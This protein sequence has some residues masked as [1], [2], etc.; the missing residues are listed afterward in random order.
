MDL[1]LAISQGIGISLATGVRT[2][3]APLVVGA[4]ARADAV[5]D[6]EHTGFEFLESVWWLALMLAFVI[7]VW[8][9]DRSDVEI[10][11]AAWVVVSMGLGALLFAGA[12]EDEDYFGT[13]GL[14][15]GMLGA[16]LGFAAARAFFGGAAERLEARGESGGTI[17][18]LGDLAAVALAALAVVAPPVSYLA[19]AF[20]L[21]VLL[22]R[23]RREGQ[24]YEG[25]R[26]LR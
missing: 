22:A 5:I 23:R 14:I 20:C 7:V 19:V 1:F 6:F 12:L 18:T 26:I 24:K 4:M 9:I 16:L 10:H 2:F 17:R 8:L 21:W 11:D 13:A 25:L 3:L 15:P